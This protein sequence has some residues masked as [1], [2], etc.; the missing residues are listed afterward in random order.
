LDYS[1]FDYKKACAELTV[2]EL[3]TILFKSR[4]IGVTKIITGCWK[5][6]KPDDLIFITLF[7]LYGSVVFLY[8]LLYA[9][10][11]YLFYS[12]FRKN[13]KKDILRYSE[14][15]WS[16]NHVKNILN[17]NEYTTFADIQKLW[18]IKEEIEEKIIEKHNQKKQVEHTYEE[19]NTE[20]IVKELEKEAKEKLT[21]SRQENDNDYLRACEDFINGEYEKAIKKLEKACQTDA[22]YPWSFYW[23]GCS[24]Y[25]N[26]DYEKAIEKFE[27]ACELDNNEHDILYHCGQAYYKIGNYRKAI[28]KLERA[29]ELDDRDFS[30]FHL[31]GDAYYQIG[32]YEKAFEKYDK[33]LESE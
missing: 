30:C 14:I 18:D 21:K 10:F 26:G 11:E 31:C 33:N 1:K 32:E 5:K 15:K 22:N 20:D 28:E 27:R 13:S 17:D 7:I 19:K 12:I 16:Q 9:T 6:Y 29:C 8:S 24:Y 4:M 23:C 2:R 3:E 25:Y